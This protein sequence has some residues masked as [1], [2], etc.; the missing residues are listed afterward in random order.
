MGTGPHLPAWAREAFAAALPPVTAA[1]AAATF[2][3]VDALRGR[4]GGRHSLEL[5]D[6]RN[7]EAVGWSWEAE[8]A[9]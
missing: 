1:R 9:A 3:S 4:G 6:L 7:G 5:Y 8:A 2:V